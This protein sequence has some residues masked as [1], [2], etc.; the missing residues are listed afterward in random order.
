M[1]GIETP[2]QGA[3]FACEHR[4]TTGVLSSAG[5]GT[6]VQDDRCPR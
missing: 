2:G 3:P 4:Q 6:H 5:N 1:V